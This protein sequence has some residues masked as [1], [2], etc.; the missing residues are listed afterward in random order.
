MKD[1]VTIED[2]VQ[3]TGISKS[4]VSRVLTGKG[5]V[6]DE[7]RNTVKNAALELEYVPQKRHNKTVNDMV[8]IV[9]CQ[10]DS[11]AQIKLCKSISTSL[12]ENG[13][14]SVVASV[15]FG[16]NTIYDYLD[17]AYEKHFG[18]L[19]ILGALETKKLRYSLMNIPCPVVLLNQSLSGIP[20]CSIILEDKKAGYDATKYLI[21][22][23]HKKILFITGYDNA[24]AIIDREKGFLQAMKEAGI[25][26]QELILRTDFTKE[27]SEKIA[28]QL[29]KDRFP[30]TALLCAT[31]ELLSGILK[32]F[33]K[34]KI[35]IPDQISVMSF[36]NTLLTE[37][38]EPKISVVS[39]DFIEIGKQ[40]ADLLLERVGKPYNKTKS[41]HSFA[42]LL[43]RDSV[44]TVK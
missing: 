41:I 13:F 31:D 21:D 40:M 20:T 33:K 9:S 44:K 6:S 2:I 14:K 8:M 34:E 42:T 10:L 4:T 24:T 28:Y 15:E 23:G 39:Y 37:I 7:V 43:L 5:Y 12:Q 16:S 25:D 18:G 32:V 36:E 19:I 22:K 38:Y 11:D 1:R 27:N 3:R 30:Y 35:Q 29:I 17:Y 26:A